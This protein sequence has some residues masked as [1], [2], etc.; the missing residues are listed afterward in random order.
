MGYDRSM[1]VGKHFDVVVD[2]LDSTIEADSAE[3]NDE[4]GLRAYTFTHDE[5][6]TLYHSDAP[7]HE[8]KYTAAELSDFAAENYDRPGVI[9]RARRLFQYALIPLIGDKPL[10]SR[11]LL[12]QPYS[13][14]A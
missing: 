2:A 14:E 12:D 4:R 8:L 9:T 3:R 7:E 6:L 13:H 10:E 5:G 11:K 1:P